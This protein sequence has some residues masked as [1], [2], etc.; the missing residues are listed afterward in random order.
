MAKR[1]TDT[2]KWDKAW[3]RKLGSKLRDVR[4]YVLDKCD[5]AGVIEIDLDTFEHFIGEPVS[6]A[7]ISAA[8][9]GEVRVI[10]DK[11]F[12]PAF[13][14]FQYKMAVEDLNPANKVH[15]SVL[16]R[17]RNLGIFKPLGS[18]LEGAKDKDKELDKDKD[19]SKVF[20]NIPIITREQWTRKYDPVWLADQLD[21]AYEFH[22]ADPGKVPVNQGAWMRKFTTWLA[23]NWDKHKTQKTATPDTGGWEHLDGVS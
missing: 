5:H 21:R 1:F 7:E 14:E 10:G 12:V 18:P 4:Q 17:L 6:L 20:E 8:F 11:I 19:K 22:T 16:S 23:N 9:R 3:F 2:G 13:I 15:A